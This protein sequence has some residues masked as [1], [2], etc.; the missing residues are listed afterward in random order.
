MVVYLAADLLWSTRIKST[1]ES[2]GIQARPVRN[3]EMLEAR[4]ADSPVRGL[5]VDLEAGDA[6]L[7]L[8]RRTAAAPLPATGERIRVVAFGP[9]VAV[10]RLD[11]ARAAGADEVLPRGS[12]DRRLIEILRSLDGTAPSA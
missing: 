9:H 11:A 6:A 10:D 2:L 7:D 3:P 4:L 5:I 1:A 8:I 12:F